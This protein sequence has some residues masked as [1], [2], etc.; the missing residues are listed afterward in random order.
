MSDYSGS[1]NGAVNGLLPQHREKIKASEISDEV[2]TARGYRSIV[3]AGDL[4]GMFG[5][6]QRRPGLLIPLYDVH[7]E[8]FSQQ[9]RPDEPRTG[10]D[11]KLLKYETPAGLKMALDVPPGC[12]R[13]LSDPAVP[14][15]ITEGIKKADSL[16]SVGLCAVALLGVWTWR[17]TNDKGGT[18]ALPDWEA[19]ALNGRRV[20]IAFD[21]DALWNPDI[22]KAAERLGRFLEGRK[23]EIAFV[24]L[25]SENGSKVGVDDYLANHSKDE[26][27]ALVCQEWRPL[28][29]D[30]KPAEKPPEGPLLPVDQLLG[31]ISAVLDRYVRLPSRDAVLAIGLWVLHTWALDGAHATPYLVIQSP[32]KRSGKTRL[33]EVLA[34][35]VR[36][37]WMIASASQSAIFRKI[38]EQ[39]PTLILDEVDAI[40]AG[41]AENAESLRGVLNAGNRPGAVVARTVGEGANLKSADFEVYCPKILAGI[42]TDRWPDTILDRSIRI[43]LQRKKKDEAVARFRHRNASV[44]TEPL[45]QA[46]GVWAA[47]HIPTLRDAEPELPDDLDDR[48]QEGW[49]ALFAIADLAGNET[50]E[51]A[52]KAAVSLARDAPKDDDGDGVLLLH[53][54]KHLFRE[55]SA[56]PSD[57]IVKKLNEDAELPF[58]GYRKEAGINARGLSRLLKPFGIK[59]KGIRV[60]PETPKGYKSADFAEVWERYPS[61]PNKGVASGDPPRGGFLSATSATT[62]PQSQ[63]PGAFDPPQTANVADRESAAIP[64]SKADVADVAEQNGQ[65]GLSGHANST[66][67]DETVRRALERQP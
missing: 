41:N 22:H 12:R 46:L 32:T 58:S 62:A 28:A 57:T 63:K 52:R 34:L 49:E 36:D 19:I 48:A 67:A 47:H 25:P 15:W 38:A 4:N 8:R 21:S 60:G 5:A 29:S 6:S 53:A 31:E 61:E 54:L 50:G 35:L 3:K 59:S 37:P 16:T 23:A 45:R 14:L 51:P 43:T 13:N 1:Q 20:I 17:G 65:P 64:H 30:D 55:E 11:G 7:G 2:A 9:L 10:K 42:A 39:R 24:Y 33:Q 26:L 56:L 44:E 18:T 27:L 40:F 66:F